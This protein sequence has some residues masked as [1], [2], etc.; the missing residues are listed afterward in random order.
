MRDGLRLAWRGFVIVILTATNV[1]QI[2]HEHYLGAF[3][4]GTLISVVWFGNAKRAGHSDV[5]HAAW[6]YGLGA[7]LGTVAG[8]ALMRLVYG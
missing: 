3:L 8:M 7:G 4:V 1:F 6:W 2:A 5:R